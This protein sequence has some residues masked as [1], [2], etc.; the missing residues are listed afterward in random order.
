MP[1]C[2]QTFDDV[3]SY[4]AS[5]STCK[6]PH[7]PRTRR[8]FWHWGHGLYWPSRH[9]HAHKCNVLIGDLARRCDDHQFL[10]V[11]FP[12]SPCCMGSV[13]GLAASEA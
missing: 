7:V 5:A 12:S 11:Y 2:E 13:S 6:N 3:A 4:E 8:V 10:T 1:V 9:A